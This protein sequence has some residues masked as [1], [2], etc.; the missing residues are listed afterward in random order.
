MRPLT[1]LIACLLLA[2]PALASEPF[3]SDGRVVAKIVVGADAPADD[4]IL[5][6]QIA[7]YLQT[8]ATEYET[9]VA[10][11]SDG[12][13][14]DDGRTYILIGMPQ[15]NPLVAE[16]LEGEPDGPYLRMLGDVMV[17]SGGTQSDVSEAAGMFARGRRSAGTLTVPDARVTEVIDDVADEEPEAERAESE[18]DA[19]VVANGSA[20]APEP[21]CE[22]RAYCSGDAVQSVAADCSERAVEFCPHGCDGG[23]CKPSLLSRLWSRLAFWR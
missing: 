23:V 22:P 10:T 19:T 8:F 20:A 11:T 9:G 14:V 3:V 2:A 13:D 18:P 1:L 16:T 21:T 17:V 4:V 5:G 12:V 7:A 6:A 15:N